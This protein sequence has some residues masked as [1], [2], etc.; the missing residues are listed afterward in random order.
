MILPDILWAEYFGG[1]SLGRVRGLGLLLSQGLAAFGPPFFGFLFDATGGYSVSFML[2]G[3]ALVTSA[4]LSL[5]IRPP[6]K[7]GAVAPSP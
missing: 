1:H 3:A 7:A 5:L 2:F 4:L 6:E